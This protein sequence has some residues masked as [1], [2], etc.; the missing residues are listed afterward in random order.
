MRTRYPPAGALAVDRDGFSRAV[1]AA[2]E[3]EPLIEIDGAR[4]RASRRRTGPTRRRHGPLT[5]PLLADA[6][7]T[8][9]GEDSLAFF[10]AIAPIVYRESID[11]DVAWFQSRYDRRDRR[12][13]ARTTSTPLDGR[14][15]T[16][17]RRAAFGEKTEFKDWERDTSYFEAAF[18]SR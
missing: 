18:P 3:A 16:L 11:F 6:I 5:S 17:H 12:G 14:G 15:K 10:D 4:S 7:Q 9:T 13:P 8:L 1:G 2:I